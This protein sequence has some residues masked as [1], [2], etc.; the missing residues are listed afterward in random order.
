MFLKLNRLNFFK[1]LSLLSIG[2]VFFTIL[3]GFSLNYLFFDKFYIARKEATILNIRKE[4]EKQLIYTPS[5]LYSYIE[6]AEDQYGLKIDLSSSYM[7][8]KHKSSIL[9]RLKKEKEFFIMRD[10]SKMGVLFL[11]Y[12]A[13]LP[14]N[15]ILSIRVSL[16]VMN[17]HIHEVFIFNIFIALI[18]ILFSYILVYIFSKKI[19]NN[20]NYLKQN[21][22]KISKLDFSKKIYL[23]TGDELEEL[24]D[25]LNTMSTELNKAITSLKSFVSNASH[26]LKTP[27]SVLCLYSKALLD[28]RIEESKKEEYLKVLLKKSLEMKE[29]TE[30]L[31]YLSRFDSP[32][33]KLSLKSTD[34][35]SLLENSIESYDYFEFS[36][37]LSINKQLEPI[38][39]KVDSKIFTIAI[40][41]LVQNMLKYAPNNSEVSITLNSS[42]ISFENSF[43]STIDKTKIFEPFYR[44]ENA[45]NESIEGNGLGLSLV[46][47]VLNLHNLEYCIDIKNSIFIFKIK[48]KRGD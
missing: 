32:D 17:E 10:M 39:Q 26:E 22:K 14:E 40:N 44:G 18:S 24:G 12:Y 29:V 46:K 6:F 43:C 23:K 27:I 3:T 35:K 25:S 30:T 9:N 21:A 33:F 20:I 2:V 13:L 28:K 8:R 7:H 37:D 36:K 45:L 19:T 47:K 5:T 48:L 42:S 4:I 11:R 15:S 31:L 1:K 16:S 38:I 41:N 34:L